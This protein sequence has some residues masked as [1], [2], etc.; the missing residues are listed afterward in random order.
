MEEAPTYYSLH[1]CREEGVFTTIIDVIMSL[2]ATV[3]TIL[4]IYGA[5]WWR[6][7]FKNR[8]VIAFLFIPAVM[9]V[10]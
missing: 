10:S 4:L 3:M 2:K 6:K 9:I 7:A 1:D 5:Y 8:F